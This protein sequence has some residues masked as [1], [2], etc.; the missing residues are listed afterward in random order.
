MRAR[1][2][3]APITLQQKGLLI[4]E[5][6]TNL[7]PMSNAFSAWTMTGVSAT[8]SSDFR[9]FDN[10]GVW[11]LTADGTSSAKKSD[12]VFQVVQTLSVYLRRGTSNFAQLSLSGE[13]VNFANFDLLTGTIGSRSVTATSTM[14]PWRDGWYRCTMTYT[15]PTAS[16]IVIG[17]VGSATS[18]RAALNYFYIRRRCSNRTSPIP[19]EL[20]SHNNR[21]LHESR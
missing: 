2:D 3:Y 1:M 13:S 14:I 5:E 11:L 16:A 21:R 7:L 6:R 15:S 17:I 18:A 12:G 8:S 20:H 10:E 19:Y 9:I 4:E